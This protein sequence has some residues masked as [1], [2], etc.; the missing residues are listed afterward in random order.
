MTRPAS[1]AHLGYGSCPSCGHPDRFRD[2]LCVACGTDLDEARAQ[3]D[4]LQAAYTYLATH[5][6]PAAIATHHAARAADAVDAADAAAR[7][8]D[9]ADAL[10]ASEDAAGVVGASS[11]AADA[12]RAAADAVDAVRAAVHADAAG[13]VYAADAADAVDAVRA[14]VHADAADVVYAAGAAGAVRTAADAAVQALLEA[15]RILSA[16]AGDRPQLGARTGAARPPGAVTRR[17]LAAGCTLLPAGDR[18]RYSEEWLS[19]LTELPTRR[20]RA[21]H[22]RSIL[23]GTP[24][25]AWTLRRPL[26]HTPPA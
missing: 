4:A 21:A 24:R 20:A 9:A 13:V 16:L 6:C 10:G 14:A 18:A 7:A 26:K 12:V 1:P 11:Y 19:L 22:V 3:R 17:L 8:A 23:Y 25:Q 2:Q 5:V 15:E